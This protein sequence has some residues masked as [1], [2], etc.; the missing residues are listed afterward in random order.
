MESMDANHSPADVRQLTIP[1]PRPLWFGLSALVLTAA[2]IGLKIGTPVYL[3]YAAIQEIER[4]G[5]VVW[6]NPPR[7]PVWLWNWVGTDRMR[8]FDEVREVKL[9]GTDLTDETVARLSCLTSL[10]TLRLSD[11]DL[12]DAALRRLSHLPKLEALYIDGTRISDEGAAALARLKNLK[13]L[14]MASTEITDSALPKLASLS[15]LRWLDLSFTHISDAGM[16]Q[17][18]DARDE[19]NPVTVYLLG[20]ETSNAAMTALAE[21]VPGVQLVK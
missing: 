7:G 16:V 1:I 20:T 12:S 10:R 13:T 21:G 19:T 15:R 18:G 2:A 8:P 17:Y 4:A 5:G 11:T 3:R 6:T 14:N 9:T